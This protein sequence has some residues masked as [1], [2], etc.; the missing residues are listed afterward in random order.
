MRRRA[1][2]ISLS[3]KLSAHSSVTIRCMGVH[4]DSVTF[5]PMLNYE[6]VIRR[7]HSILSGFGFYFDFKD[8]ISVFYDDDQGDFLEEFAVQDI[9]EAIQI[10]ERH[11]PRGS[12]ISSELVYQDSSNTEKDLYVGLFFDHYPKYGLSTVSLFLLSQTFQ[13]ENHPES[14]TLIVQALEGLHD[15]FKALR[16]SFSLGL[17]EHYIEE[18]EEAA[19]IAQHEVNPHPIYLLDMVDDSLVSP[20]FIEVYQSSEYEYEEGSISKTKEG[21]FFWINKH[22][23]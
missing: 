15:G 9:D 3:S 11:F 12:A 10:L 5:F 13:P 18:E 23:P 14:W 22:A 19:L 6:T 2:F 16:T 1:E 21:S 7:T 17:T 20:D 4:Y 8:E